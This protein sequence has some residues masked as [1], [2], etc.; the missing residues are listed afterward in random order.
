[1]LV[2]VLGDRLGADELAGAT[3]F[4]LPRGAGLGRAR[5]DIAGLE[6]AVVL[7]VLLG[8]EATPPATAP[9]S[10]TAAP[11]AAGTGR[12]PARTE[13]GLADLRAQEVVGVELGARLHERRRRLELTALGRL[14]VGL[15]VI[16]GVG[17]AHAAGEHHDVARLDREL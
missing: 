7:V 14:G 4:L 17:V 12:L 9:S 16:D 13:P 10:S 1:T 5:E 8:V 2:A 15:V 6:V 3:A 11:F